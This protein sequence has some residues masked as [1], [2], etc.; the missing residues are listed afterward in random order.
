M[1]KQNEIRVN[2]SG[3][4]ARLEIWHGNR[5]L[6]TKL[7]TMVTHN[8]AERTQRTKSLQSKNLDIMTSGAE[9]IWAGNG[10]ENAVPISLN[11][12]V[13]KIQ[14][15]NTASHCTLG[16]GRP[17]QLKLIIH[18]LARVVGNH[19]TVTCKTTHSDSTNFTS[20]VTGSSKEKVGKVLVLMS[21]GEQW[22]YFGMVNQSD[23]T[24]SGMFSVT[25]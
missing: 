24:I 22:Y 20:E 7:D 3:H 17:G 15:S 23:S 2:T 5:W 8:K 9:T 19:L 10:A 18:S 12:L 11:T 14:T 21:D 6:S 1:P 4:G 16:N 13:S 25:Y